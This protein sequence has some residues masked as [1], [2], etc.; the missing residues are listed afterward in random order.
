MINFGNNKIDIPCPHCK[1]ALKVTFNQVTRG[2]SLHCTCGAQINLSDDGG[3]IRK[4][5]SDINKSLSSLERTI[6]KIGRR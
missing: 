1:R 3:S 2:D 6:K 5:V 4:G